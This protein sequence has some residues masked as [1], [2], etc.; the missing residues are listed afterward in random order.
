MYFVHARF[1]EPQTVDLFMLV[2]LVSAPESVN[3]QDAQEL[4]S[5]CYIGWRNRFFGTDF[6]APSTFTNWGYGQGAQHGENAADS[7][8]R[9]LYRRVDFFVNYRTLLH[10]LGVHEQSEY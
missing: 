10:F 7:F 6:W 4:I 8:S 1:L 9:S 3:F 2:C 5:S